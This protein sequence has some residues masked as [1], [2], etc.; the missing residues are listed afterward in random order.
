MLKLLNSNV[1]P[2]KIS[3]SPAYAGLFFSKKIKIKLIINKK[4]YTFVFRI[5][6]KI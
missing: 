3:W 1:R 4:N 2:L 6:F 5:K